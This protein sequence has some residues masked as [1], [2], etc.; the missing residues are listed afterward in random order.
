MAEFDIKEEMVLKIAILA[1]RFAQ[2]LEWYIDTILQVVR[3]AGKI[4]FLLN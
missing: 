4:F 3:I 1:E 2:R